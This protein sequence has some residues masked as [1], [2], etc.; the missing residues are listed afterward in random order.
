MGEVGL[1]RGRAFVVR[2]GGCGGV[3]GG[4]FVLRCSFFVVRSSLSVV[5]SS[6]SVG[7]VWMVVGGARDSACGCST[8]I[9]ME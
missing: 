6:L 3:E 5:R 4:D 1:G 7:G 9:E 8:G 2:F